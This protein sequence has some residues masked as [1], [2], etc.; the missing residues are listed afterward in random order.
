M[1][2]ITSH[3]DF[4]RKIGENLIYEKLTVKDAEHQTMIADFILKHVRP[5]DMDG[6]YDER[7]EIRFEDGSCFEVD[8]EAWVVEDPVWRIED[9]HFTKRLTEEECSIKEEPGE[10]TTRT[11][12]FHDYNTFTD[13]TLIGVSVSSPARQYREGG[14]WFSNKT[15]PLPVLENDEGDLCVSMH[16]HLLNS[17]LP[18][19]IQ[20][21]LD[22][23][24]EAEFLM[25]VRAEQSP[26][27][28]L[29]P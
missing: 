28:D 7:F 23:G 9:L 6:S 18:I 22:N 21:L 3:S 27:E 19:P 10:F 25:K 14:N 17:I 15:G 1:K 12:S 5:H 29:S 24:Y 13:E 20:L 8:Y 11:I 4:H 26:E 2:F 16:L